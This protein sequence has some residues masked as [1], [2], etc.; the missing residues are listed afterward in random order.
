MHKIVDLLK[1]LSDETRL[2][3][4]CLIV[5]YG[6]LCVCELSWALDLS[7]PKISRHLARMR[8]EGILDTRRDGQWVLYSLN[9][10]IAPGIRA[11]VESI[12]A[13]DSLRSQYKQDSERLDAMKDRPRVSCVGSCKNV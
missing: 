11:I 5:N 3:S 2:R 7:Q 1:S 6:E 9:A 8:T 4:M 12:V 10:D 13:Q